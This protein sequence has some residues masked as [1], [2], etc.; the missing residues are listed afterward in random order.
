[1]NDNRTRRHFGTSNSDYKTD[2]LRRKT[3]E[4]IGTSVAQGKPFFAYVAPVAPHMP[5]TAAARDTHTY[6]GVKAPRP[7]SFN[8]RDV[9]DKPLWIRRLPRL[10][11][12]KIA[13]LDRRHEKRAESL[14][15][16][17]DLVAG[18]VNKLNNKGVMNNTY[19]FFASDNGWHHGEHR[20][21]SGKWRPY[22]ESIRVPLL[23]RGPGVAAGTTTYRLALNTDYTPTFTSLAGAQIPSYV[24]GRSLKPV[25]KGT[26]TTWRNAILLEAPLR[27][28]PAYRGIRTS[29]K[30]KY[31]EYAGGTKELYYLGA[32]PKELTDKYNP[33]APPAGLASRLRALESCAAATCR[34]AENGQ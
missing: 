29:T 5:A 1:V 32:D 19:I 34:S 31:V 7:P 26:A 12:D 6:D 23:V 18:V 2:V 8:E 24:D 21:P 17:D 9:S 11:A 13:N 27:Y 25:L 28:S 14:Q 22:E 16:V 4:F 10:S 3:N 33:N 20:I 30:R 15:A